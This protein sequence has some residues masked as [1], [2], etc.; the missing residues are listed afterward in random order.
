[1]KTP[2]LQYFYEDEY[3]L[4]CYKP[5]GFAT[6]SRKIGVCDIV[7]LIKN[8]IAENSSISGDPYLAVIH[9]LDQPVGGI[10]VFAKTPFAAT[11]LNKQLQHHGFGKYYRAL[12]TG[13]LPSQ[14]GTLENYLIKNGRTNTSQICTQ[15]TP[16]AK[17][18]RLHYKIVEK[19]QGFFNLGRSI[20]NFTTSPTEVDIRLD[21]GRHHQIRVQFAAAGTPIVGDTKYGFPAS[22]NAEH[23]KGQGICLCAYRLDFHHPKTN[24]PM[25]FEISKIPEIP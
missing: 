19:G 6:Q 24:K 25:H 14:Q 16:G 15:K 1:M 2:N 20:F 4:V 5:P 3:I 23:K 11:E 22:W 21:T 8:H 7:N 17:F 9:R 12:I 13:D 18:A 10:L